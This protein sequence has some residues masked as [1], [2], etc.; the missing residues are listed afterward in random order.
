M[1]ARAVAL[2]L[3]F[4]LDRRR[5]RGPDRRDHFSLLDDVRH[6]DAE[7]LGHLPQ[8]A[9]GSFRGVDDLHGRRRRGHDAH[10]VIIRLRS[11][12]CGRR[13]GVAVVL[14]VADLGL[15]GREPVLWGCRP[16]EGGVV[17]VFGCVSRRVGRVLEP[18]RLGRRA[19]RRRGRSVLQPPGRLIRVGRTVRRRGGG[20]VLEP[21]G[22]R[23]LSGVR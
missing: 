11:Q 15:V 12:V 4:D 21:P 18:A 9:D 2:V 3:V 19:V 17:V 8:F 23:L 14:L 16:V 13:V 10:V 22:R 6:V 5:P 20:R 7:L 1:L